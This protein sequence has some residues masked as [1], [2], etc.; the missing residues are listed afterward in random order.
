MIYLASK[1]EIGDR[2]RKERLQLGLTQDQL[3]NR[4]GIS[5]NALSDIERGNNRPDIKTA[6]NLGNIFHLSLEEIYT[7]GKNEFYF[8]RVV[9]TL[10]RHVNRL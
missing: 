4:I 10:G 8:T 6:C 1:S 9:D 2:I 5:R 7:K 3:S